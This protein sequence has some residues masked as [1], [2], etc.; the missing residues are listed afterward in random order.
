MAEKEKIKEH[1]KPLTIREKLVIKILIVIVQML[2][3]YEYE[4]QFEQFYDD[5]KSTMD[6]C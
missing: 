3:P 2:K 6:K 4:H 1:E 5:I